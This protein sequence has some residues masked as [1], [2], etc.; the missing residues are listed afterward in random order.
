[1]AGAAAVIRSHVAKCGTKGNRTP[2]KSS[3][4][5]DAT[6]A[7]RVGGYAGATFSNQSVGRA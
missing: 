4:R 7:Q 6:A 1:M 3:N 5:S 2:P